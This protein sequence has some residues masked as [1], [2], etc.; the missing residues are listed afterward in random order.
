MTDY[1]APWSRSLKLSTRLVLALMG[2]LCL[3]MVWFGLYRVNLGDPGGWVAMASCGVLPVVMLLTPLWAPRGYRITDNAVVIRKRVGD[4]QISFDEIASAEIRDSRE[5]LAGAM[6]VMG[7]GG[8][9]GTYGR[10]SGGALGSFRASVTNDGPVV[11]LRMK[12]GNPLVISPEYP[13]DFLRELGSRTGVQVQERET[14]DQP[15]VSYRPPLSPG[16][17]V[18]EVASLALLLVC[19][20][21][22]AHFWD[23]LP[24]TVPTH[25]GFLGKP[26]SWG[27]KSR[28]LILP[29]M[30]L[31]TYV[32]LTAMTAIIS[33]INKAP[34]AHPKARKAVDLTRWAFG[35]I[36]CWIL[37]ISAYT[38]WQTALIALGKSEGLGVGFTL[39]TLLGFILGPAALIPMALRSS[40]SEQE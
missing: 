19:F 39:V 34:A 31:V 32:V 20:A 28:I 24:E 2:G 13:T 26:D 3:G 7:S 30:A 27:P 17:L 4:E 33:R 25:F 23:K 1:R 29:G 15:P 8:Y 6:K 21:L 36:K 40:K 37:F 18:I 5:V 10:F 16:E 11:V 9:Y 12:H 35:T 38:I 14:T 22:T